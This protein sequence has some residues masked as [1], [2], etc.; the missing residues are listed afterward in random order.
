M[1]ELITL[2]GAT[3]LAAMAAGCSSA[4]YKASDF[5]DDLYSAHD[6]SA[7]AARRQAEAEARQ[8]EAAARQAQWEARLAEIRA[9]TAEEEYYAA[10]GNPYQDVLADTYESAYAR[11]LAGF[12]SPTYR[13][14]SSY[15][16]LRYSGD[17]TYASAYDPAFYN[18][19]VS[20]DQVWVEPRYITS[21]FG[22]WGAT[23]VYGYGWY[24]GWHTPSYAWWGYPRYS[25]WD[26]NVAFNSWYDPW[27]GPGWGYPGWYP[28]WS[29]PHHHPGWGPGGG[30]PHPHRPSA[31]IVRR[32]SPYT[33][34]GSG[35]HYNSG[36]RYTNG[37]SAYQRPPQR[38]SN[39]RRPA[40][41][42]TESI[43]N[44]R[45]NNHNNPYNR[46]EDRGTN[47]Y[48]RGNSRSSYNSNSSGS[49]SRGGS[50]YG[51]G[52]GSRGGSGAGRNAGGR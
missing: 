35:R 25:W 2:L 8:A 40:G 13:M 26:W 39:N 52:G 30:R 37:N 33:P 7:I 17:Y 11:R 31:T 23:P 45:Y 51:G 28:G 22:T 19:M 44:N 34:P 49:Y 14:P 4:Y 29:Y 10:S 5:S 50:G 32:P 3:L 6:R 42:S 36:S 12:S 15:F 41:T 47:T 1:K 46:T 18:V 48:N 20:G 9:Q 38:P 24:M 21:M 43:G 27:W 16:N